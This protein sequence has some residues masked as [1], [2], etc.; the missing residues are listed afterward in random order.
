MSYAPNLTIVKKDKLTNLDEI[1][2]FKYR[3][4]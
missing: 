2:I 1:T 4:E 3:V